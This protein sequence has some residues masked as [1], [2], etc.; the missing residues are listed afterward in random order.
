M[1][2]FRISY[3]WTTDNNEL[4]RIKNVWFVVNCFRI[5]YL[6]TTDN[7]SW[8]YSWLSSLVVNC[9]RIS[10]LWTTDNNRIS[11]DTT[12]T[13][14]WIAFEYR[15]FELLITTLSDN[16]RYKDTLWIAFEYRIF[17]LLITTCLFIIYPTL[18]CELL[19]NIVSLNYW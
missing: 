17:E 2:C 14:L 12:T 15:I 19:S 13:P 18:S 10:Y 8:V 11:E 3:L 6:W 16:L 4:F 1:N 7:N 5:S 9:F